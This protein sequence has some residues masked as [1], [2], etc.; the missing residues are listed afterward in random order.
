MQKIQLYA[1]KNA[2]GSTSVV[3][4]I[5]NVDGVIYQS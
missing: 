3:P 1:L 2:G 4:V 5:L